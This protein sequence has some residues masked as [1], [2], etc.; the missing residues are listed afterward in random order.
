MQYQGFDTCTR[1]DVLEAHVSSRRVAVAVGTGTLALG[2]IAAFAASSA[3]ASTAQSQA[4]SAVAAKP[5]IVTAGG[6]RTATAKCPAGTHATGGGYTI[7]HCQTDQF[8]TFAT[9]TKSHPT[10]DGTGWYVELHSLSPK[11]TAYAVCSS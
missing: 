1:N 2:G 3:D 8:N 4:K 5:T 6:G 11:V 9:V 10:P 7:D